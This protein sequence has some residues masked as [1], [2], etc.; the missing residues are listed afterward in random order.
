MIM[1]KEECAALTANRGIE[2]LQKSTTNVK[3]KPIDDP[4]FASL[5]KLANNN[6]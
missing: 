2:M 5:A 3:N 6:V 4:R 1:V